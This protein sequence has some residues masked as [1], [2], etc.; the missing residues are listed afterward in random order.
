MFVSL[1][2]LPFTH[3]LVAD[4][5]GKKEYHCY[6]PAGIICLDVCKSLDGA[7]TTSFCKDLG[8]PDIGP[9]CSH[10]RIP[11]ENDFT[12]FRKKMGEESYQQPLPLQLAYLSGF[13]YGK[14]ITS[15]A[16][17]LVPTSPTLK[18]VTVLKKVIA[19]SHNTR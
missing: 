19:E 3:R 15:P 5:Y 16:G 10:G 14:L 8:D 18:V 13:F 7:G 4:C 2:D 1:I 6:D 17:Y 11:S 12:N 9:C